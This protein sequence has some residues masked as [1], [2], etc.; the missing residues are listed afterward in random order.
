MGVLD[1]S[2]LFESVSFQSPE[3]TRWTG[4]ASILFINF[5]LWRL[6][7]AI[8]VISYNYLNRISSKFTSVCLFVCTPYGVLG[9][10]TSKSGVLPF[11]GPNKRGFLGRSK[12]QY[13]SLSFTVEVGRYPFPT[14]PDRILRLCSDEGVNMRPSVHYAD[15]ITVTTGSHQSS[16]RVHHTLYACSISTGS[17]M[18]G[19][20]LHPHQ[21]FLDSL[22]RV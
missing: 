18:T 7:F 11:P 6:L 20:S 2:V 13:F 3:V 12:L 9:S 8:S 22:A 10:L 21:P 4:F 1:Q 14:R 17:R 5:A 15:G 16:V 19:R